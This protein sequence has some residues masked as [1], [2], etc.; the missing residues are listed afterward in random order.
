MKKSRKKIARFA[1]NSRC[2]SA[3]IE[4]TKETEP[5]TWTVL[6]YTSICVSSMQ[7]MNKKKAEKKHWLAIPK[8]FKTQNKNSCVYIDS[9]AWHTDMRLMAKLRFFF[10]FCRYRLLIVCLFPLSVPFIL[11][12]LIVHIYMWAGGSQWNEE[13]M[14]ANETKCKIAQTPNRKKFCDDDDESD[15][16]NNKDFFFI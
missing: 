9:F 11:V 10:S 1:H 7:T 12:E 4:N 8:N 14:R 6:Q 2:W 3:K 16:F 13:A 5:G 15:I